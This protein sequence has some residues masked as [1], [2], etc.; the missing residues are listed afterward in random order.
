MFLDL[1][2]HLEYRAGELPLLAEG[3]IVEFDTEFKNPRDPAKKRRMQ[4]PYEVVRSVL[5]Y[6]TERPGLSGLTQYVE[7]RAVES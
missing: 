5:K 2:I 7:W 6:A 4:G 1:P 3:T